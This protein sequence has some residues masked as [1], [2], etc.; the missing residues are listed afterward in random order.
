MP[1]KKAHIAAGT[2]RAEL[3]SQSQLPR[4]IACESLQEEAL[5][6]LVR[7]LDAKPKRGKKPV[8]L[9]SVRVSMALRSMGYGTDIVTAGMLHD[10][11]EKSALSA[12]QIARRF[13]VGVGAIVQATTNDAAIEDPLVRYMDSVMRCAEVGR[14]ALLVRAADLIDNCDRLL[15]IGGTARLSRAAAKLRMLI[16]VARVAKVDE[17]MLDELTRR[18]RRIGRRVG[19]LALVDKRAAA[20]AGRRRL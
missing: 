9:H 4:I 7:A 10:V 5:H 11:L 20:T 3:A 18:Y 13:G 14:D 2:P 8:A 1:L 12:A 6:F 17:R 16:D 19:G 15:A